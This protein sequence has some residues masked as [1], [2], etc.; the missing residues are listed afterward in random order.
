[1]GKPMR[2]KNA[3]ELLIG[4]HR[5]HVGNREQ[6][7]VAAQQSGALLTSKRLL[8]SNLKS[9]CLTMLQQPQHARP[10]ISDGKGIF[11]AMLGPPV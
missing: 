11:E 8:S 2:E 1:M 10:I 6:V 9:S 7:G 3:L 4:S 5:I